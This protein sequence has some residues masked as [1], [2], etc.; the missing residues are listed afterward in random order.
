MLAYNKTIIQPRCGRWKWNL[1]LEQLC[2][3]ACI[4]FYNCDGGGAFL[5]KTHMKIGWS[6]SHWD[7]SIVYCDCSW[8]FIFLSWRNAPPP[9]RS[10][11]ATFQSWFEW[12]WNCASA[13]HTRNRVEV[14]CGHG[15]S[16]ESIKVLIWR[17]G[18]KLKMLVLFE[19]AAGY[20]IFKVS[21]KL[22]DHVPGKSLIC[23]VTE[24]ASNISK[25]ARFQGSASFVIF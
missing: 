5:T 1:H 16:K 13:T 4:L 23:C 7:F 17:K 15:L 24:L 10:T 11:L 25:I 22:Y 18:N 2:V 20:A 14:L 9:L 21:V 12:R 19:T 3:S 6:L 8:L